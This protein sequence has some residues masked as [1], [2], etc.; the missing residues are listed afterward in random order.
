MLPCKPYLMQR[1]IGT[2]RYCL[3]GRRIVT[4]ARVFRRRFTQ[5]DFRT[6]Q[7]PAYRLSRSLKNKADVKKRQPVLF[8]KQ[9]ANFMKQK[10]TCLS[11][12]FL[13]LKVIRASL[14]APR[15]LRSSF[16]TSLLCSVTAAASTPRTYFRFTEKLR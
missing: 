3:L 10:S 13:S 6:R 8:S 7:N 12:S 11:Y 5:I 9:L 4:T 15:L 2:M 1:L 16:M 14:R